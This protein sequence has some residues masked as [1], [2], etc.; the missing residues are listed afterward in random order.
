MQ[1]WLMK[2][3]PESYSIDHLKSQNRGMW[4]GVRN[5]Q[6]RNFIRAMRKADMVLFYHSSIS[7]PGIAGLAKVV[8]EAYPD[9]TQFDPASAYY[10]PTSRKERPRWYAVDV[11]FVRKFK[12]PF[13][14]PELKNDPFFA[15]MLVIRRAR[16]SVQP[17]EEK[18]FK[19]ILSLRT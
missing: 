13:T 17:V 19:K 11:A 12:A 8:K 9:P 7:V 14:L 5:F 10:D 18:H 3:E 6:A 1:Y 2:S 15:D 16:L 4:D